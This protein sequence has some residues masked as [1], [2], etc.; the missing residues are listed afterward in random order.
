M[1]SEVVIAV[2]TRGTDVLIVKRKEGEGL[3]RWQFPGG[4]IK[5]HETE[6]QAVI[7]EAAEETACRITVEN[8]IGIRIH[9]YT[10]KN[11]SYWA[12]NYVDG[13][14]VITDNE[15]DEI[16]WVNKNDIVNYFSTPIYDEVS[17]FLEIT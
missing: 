11:I 12:C 2:I 3:L 7:R 16:K 10:Q 15:L 14:I 13:T 8:L 9:P 5:T 6:E 4:E 17:K 1:K